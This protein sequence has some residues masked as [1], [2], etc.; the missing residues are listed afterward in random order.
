M[1]LGGALAVMLVLGIGQRFWLGSEVEQGW[2][3][4]FARATQRPLR[5]LEDRID[6]QMRALNDRLLSV[7]QEI[8]ELWE[9]HRR[10]EHHD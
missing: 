7:E 10:A 4:R 5:V 9:I 2:G 8:A 6:A 3:I 1:G